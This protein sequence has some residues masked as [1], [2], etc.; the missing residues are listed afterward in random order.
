[1][2]ILRVLVVE[3]YE[4]FRRFLSSKL[5]K[6]QA[7]QLITEVS[8]GLEAVQKAAELKPDLV[9]L[10]IGLPKLN[11]IEAARRI[12]S[13]S[14]MSKIIFLSQESSADVVQ[15]A[16]NTGAHGYVIKDDAGHELLP[17]VAAVLRGDAHP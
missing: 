8:N 13:L 16:L 11:G 4:P 15:E 9:L 6:I 12:R 7:V 5:N 14:P 3:D 10:D 2:S 1:M 17:T